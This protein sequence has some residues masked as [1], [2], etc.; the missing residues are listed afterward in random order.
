MSQLRQPGDYPK[1]NRTPASTPRVHTFMAEPNQ[2]KNKKVKKIKKNFKETV[3]PELLEREQFKT[4]TKR[5]Q[6]KI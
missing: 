3:A 1:N 6:T 5:V 4:A 2:K